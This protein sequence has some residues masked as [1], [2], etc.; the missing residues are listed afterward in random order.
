[1]RERVFLGQSIGRSLTSEHAR[2][3]GDES[4]RG[5]RWS[6]DSIAERFTARRDDD[7][8]RCDIFC[9]MRHRG[10]SE[11]V[12]LILTA[13]AAGPL[14]GYAI[15][16][17]VEEFSAGQLRLRVA[18]LYGALDRLGENGL[19]VV[20]RE[21]VTNGRLRRYYQLTEEG[22]R[23]LTAETQRLAAHARVASARLG[24]RIA[25]GGGAS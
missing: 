3:E 16:R 17:E 13:L 19:V 7:T 25:M 10:L 18:T 15:V 23:V 8:P 6:A 14:H 5:T 9:C 20:D 4:R 12:F 24:L 21:E 11:Q 2:I 22:V 1:M